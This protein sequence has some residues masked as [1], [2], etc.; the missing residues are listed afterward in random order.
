M[1]ACCGIDCSACDIRLAPTNPDIAEKMVKIFV[2]MGYKDAKPDWFQCDG[3]HG[4]REK[5]WSSNCKI[6]ACCF[7]EKHLQNC[8]QC[9]E[10]MCDIITEF[11]NDGHKHHREGVERLKSMIKE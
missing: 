5:H 3:C 4:D 8:S 10:F 1:I 11:A 6:L 9:D 2:D 7:D